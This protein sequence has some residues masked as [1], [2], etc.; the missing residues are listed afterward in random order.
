M[1][2][3]R[4]PNIGSLSTPYRAHYVIGLI[5]LAWVILQCLMGILQRILLC[6][7]I[8][9]NIIYLMRKIHLYSGIILVLL[10]KVN[11]VIGWAM[12]S[13]MAGLAVS[14]A[15]MAVSLVLLLLYIYW[16]SG[17]IS[18]EVYSPRPVS[19]YNDRT[20]AK[21]YLGAPIAASD[22]TVLSLMNLP[23]CWP[24]VRNSSLFL[25]NDMIYAIPEPDFHPGGR[26]VIEEIRGREVDRFM[27]GS[28]FTESHPNQPA[29][30]HPKQSME[31]VG[32][33][34]AALPPNP[35]CILND[36]VFMIS[37]LVRVARDVNIFYFS[38]TSGSIVHRD[39]TN[40]RHIGQYFV[41]RAFGFT[42]LYTCLLSQRKDK[43]MLREQLLNSLVPGNQRLLRLPLAES[44]MN[45]Q[46]TNAF[47]QLG[48]TTTSFT[49]G[50]MTPF[51]LRG[52]SE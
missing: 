1:I 20:I 29:F 52:N 40:M 27:Y 4:H 30:D 24:Q 28:M 23:Y 12:T 9:P 26:K 21:D 50:G 25:Y 36:R 37:S 13:S 34:L 47:G 32:P 42:R 44:T 51:S 33:P 49:V 17:N 11:V 16:V 39:P 10:G 5:V 15:F 19:R 31:I 2:Q 38:P 43:R 8:N 22:P 46:R 7:I 6:C 48:A 41:V 3:D 18:Q 14:C 35:I 45:A